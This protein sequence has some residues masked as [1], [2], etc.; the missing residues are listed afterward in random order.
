M[1]NKY[2]RKCSAFLVFKKCKPRLH[3]DSCHF[4]QSNYQQANKSQE[5]LMNMEGAGE[6]TLT[7]SWKKWRL[8]QMLQQSVWTFLKRLRLELPYD[9]LHDV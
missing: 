2:M 7:P 5:T 9:S 1:A 4:C 6:G 3:S 8:V